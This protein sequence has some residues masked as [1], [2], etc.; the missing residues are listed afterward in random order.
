MDWTDLE[1]VEGSC[2]HP[3]EPSG[4]HKMLGSSWVA[5]QLADSQEGLSSMSDVVEYHDI[6]ISTMGR[7]TLYVRKEMVNM[8]FIRNNKKKI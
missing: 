3:N 4:F 8:C 2:E 7:F 1:P 5:A 6:C